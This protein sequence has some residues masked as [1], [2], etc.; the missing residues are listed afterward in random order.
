VIQLRR[1]LFN[2]RLIQ[3]GRGFQSAG[4]KSGCGN[5]LKCHFLP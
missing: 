4:E 5:A 2:S 3:A 1:G